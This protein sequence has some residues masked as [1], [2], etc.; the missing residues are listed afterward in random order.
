LSEP[1]SLYRLSVLEERWRSDR[2]PRVFL[3]LA[4]ELRRAGRT[5][6]AIEVL[7]DG[8]SWRPE[9]VSGWV[10][11]GRI[12]LDED[13]S[14]AAIAALEQAIERDPT[15]L[16]ASRLLTEAWIRVGDAEQ[17][18]A[19]LERSRLLSLPD[20]DYE[21]LDAGIR[22]LETGS[23][24]SSAG[25]GEGEAEAAQ[26]TQP[27]EL[28]RPAAL[29]EIDL[30]RAEPGRRGWTRVEVDETPFSDLLSPTPSSP[31]TLEFALRRGGIFDVR[32]AAQPQA[33]PA[34][35]P[36]EAPPIEAVA[37]EP[38]AVVVESPAP[39]AAEQPAAEA[40]TDIV[41][42]MAEPSE[43]AP[44]GVEPRAPIFEPQSIG[45][46]VELETEEEAAEFESP[47]GTEAPAALEAPSAEAVS[48]PAST[49]TLA[50]LYLAQGHLAEAEAEYRRVLAG[51]PDDA[52]A[53]AG[54]RAV[55]ERR[56]EASRT[57]ESDVAASMPIGLTARKL[58][59]LRG[60]YQRLRTRRMGGHASVS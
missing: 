6:R 27:F 2:S 31:A 34:A 26:R 14:P 43:A 41:G 10:A 44:Q 12:L 39:P 15:Q 25:L 52:D 22:E 29:P 47:V 5:A 50:A 45:R 30:G 23:R 49:A 54:L 33:P 21:A 38:E 1:G 4:D 51:R 36:L 48:L 11:L 35:A 42:Q 9:S 59:V 18:R 24:R 58:V 8:L 55:A 19:G 28:S 20:E 53:A 3:Q 46:E 57:E 32:P 56:A 60:L 37:I 13:D 16:V 7:R 40:S 17:A